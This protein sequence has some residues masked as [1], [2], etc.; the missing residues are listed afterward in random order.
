[1]QSR[2]LTCLIALGVAACATPPAPE[3]QTEVASSEPPRERCETVLTGSRIPQCNRGDVKVM[4]REEI[5][6]QGLLSNPAFST[7]A[8]LP[9]KSH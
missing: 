5:E 9:G 3:K 2:L 8:V 6:R 7:G 1:M 4:T